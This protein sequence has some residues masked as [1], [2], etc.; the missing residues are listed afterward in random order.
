MLGFLN[1]TPLR[2]A[3]GFGTYN[4]EFKEE[5]YADADALFNSIDANN[6]GEITDKELRLHLRQFSNFSD[7]AITNVFQMLDADENGGIDRDEVPLL[8]GCML[9]AE[10]AFADV[11]ARI[12]DSSATFCFCALIGTSPGDRTGTKLQVS[13]EQDPPC[14]T[15]IY[16]QSVLWLSPWC[17]HNCEMRN[18]LPMSAQCLDLGT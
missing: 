7:A 18:C 14:K 6:D 9:F 2:K 16:R 5:I 4:E 3:P 15:H 13:V 8:V 17:T 11:P 10:I 12:S 1:Y